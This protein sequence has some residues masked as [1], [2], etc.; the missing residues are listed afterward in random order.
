LAKGLEKGTEERRH[1][2]AISRSGKGKKLPAVSISVSI[3]RGKAPT[4]EEELKW[5]GRLSSVGGRHRKG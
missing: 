4:G 1:F 2:S 5:R 3:A